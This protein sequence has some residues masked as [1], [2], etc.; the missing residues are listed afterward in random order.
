MSKHSLIFSPS[1]AHRRLACPGSARLEAACKDVPSVYAEEGSAAHALAERCLRMDENAAKYKERKLVRV[2]TGWSML[3][4]GT[5]R[6]DGW[7]VTGEMV[8]AVQVYLDFVRSFRTPASNI[9]IE[10]RVR[11][12]EECFGTA[13]YIDA[14]AFGQILVADYKHGVGVAV[15][16]E[17]NPQAMIYAL[18]AV[19]ASPYDHSTVKVAIVQPRSREGSAI[20]T[21][22]TTVDYLRQW[23][24]E[25]LL[26]GIEACKN[27]DAPLASGSHCKFCK[28]LGVCPE[29]NKEVTAMVQMHAPAL[30]NPALMT[31]ADLARVLDKMDLA[32][33]W[34]A[35][36]EALAFRK[37]E[38]G[39]DV[40]GYKI[41]AGRNSRDWAD[42]GQAETLLESQLADRAYVRKLLSPAQ[43]EK[44]FK[45]C[46]LDAKALAPLI[47][48][49]P[50]KP[51]L[52]PAND[53]R[54]ALAPSAQRA[55]AGIPAANFNIG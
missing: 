34:L 37:V 28:A 14:Q 9:L 49:T 20:K 15:S 23:Q 21:W 40:P 45:E 32:K 50:G 27:P 31:N 35:E 24:Q 10:Q 53:K 8:E 17:G 4:A 38:S 55:F 2:N 48:T 16:P 5:K 39:E 26:P 18:G 30:P 51:T 42:I 44:A 41:V 1:S 7:E 6:T 29:V 47:A 43:A 25:V 33:S 13:D 12:T 54:P 22:D 36:V 11:V 19:L 52:A 46:S 3:Q